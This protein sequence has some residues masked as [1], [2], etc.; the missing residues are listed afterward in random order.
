MVN[1]SLNY[2]LVFSNDIDMLKDQG[3]M[4]ITD[5]PQRINSISIDQLIS[6]RIVSNHSNVNET[7]KQVYSNLYKKKF[8]IWFKS[9]KDIAIP[10]MN[11]F[12]NKNNRPG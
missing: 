3:I 9:S 1:N 11:I 2:V 12:K 4:T 6:N 7:I 5:I 10:L 8:Q